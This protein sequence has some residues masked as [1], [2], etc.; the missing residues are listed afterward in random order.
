SHG[1]LPLAPGVPQFTLRRDDK[2]V[3]DVVGRRSVIGQETEENSLY[4][5]GHAQ[6][7][8]WA[9]MAVAGTAASLSAKTAQLHEGAELQAAGGVEAVF[10]PTKSAAGVT[11]AVSGLKTGMYNLRF[12]YSNPNAYDRR[13][14][15][16]ADGAP[17]RNPEEKYRIPLWLPPTGKDQWA[18]ATLMWTLYDQTTQLKIE[19]SQKADALPGWNDTAEVLI[20]G[21]ELVRPDP[22]TFAPPPPS[23]FPELVAIPGG[24]F[25]MGGTSTEADEAPAAKV[26]L[27]PF[28]IG[29][30][31]VTNAEFEQCSPA[32]RQW[33][34]GYSWRDRE[35]VIYVDWREAA[36]YCNWL[37]QQA[38]LAPVYDEKTWDA[39]MQAEGFRLP[40][41]AEWEYVAAG[42]DEQRPYPWGKEEP[43]PYVHGNFP[44]PQVL[45]IP[46]FVR[47]QDAQGTTVVGS[48][49]AGASRDGVLDLAGNV[50]QWCTDWYQPYSPGDKTNPVET[51]ESHSRV[52]RGGSW[53]YY[54]CSQ[55]CKDREFNSQSYPGYIYI[56]FRVALSEAGWKKLGGG[57]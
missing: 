20:A 24:A 52:I 26:T 9:G 31:E 25:T 53:G 42:R 40:T 3:L 16:Q 11:F 28:A 35:P 49:P 12:R 47:S 54:G 13:L 22:P 39:N 19:C 50:A 44:G 21:I 48:F 34:D 7:R 5:P 46:A 10:I 23:V 14:T 56:G 17:L 45:E 15:L 41:E 18:T 4:L 27:S 37:S 43:K 55:R 38:K 33:R 29:K 36:R 1:D 8:L 32:H 57:K 2:L 30:Y 6:S 51:R